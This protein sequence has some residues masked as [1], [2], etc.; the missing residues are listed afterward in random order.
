MASGYTANYS[1]CQWQGE[2]KFLR[3]EFNQD[4]AKI[5]AALKA[6]EERAEEKAQAA[7][8]KADRALS[9]LEAADYNIYNLLLQSEYEGKYT[10]YKKAL[11]YDG[12]LD[13]SGIASKSNSLVITDGKLVLSET[14]QGN[15]SLGS[16]GSQTGY[17]LD[18]TEVTSTGAGMLTGFQCKLYNTY[19]EPYTPT[20]QAILTI[21]GEQVFSAKVT[22][23]SMEANA[24]PVQ[25]F[26]FGKT[27][28]LIAGDKVK[29]RLEN[30]SIRIYY[31][32]DGSHLGGTLLCTG[33]SGST[34]QLTTRAQSLPAFQRA[35]AWVRHK[36]GTVGL[37]L[38]CGDE[39]I[40]LTA[41]AQRETV[42]L[43]SGSTCTEQSYR[44]ERDL[45]AGDWQVVLDAVLGS[46]ESSMQLY[47]YGIAII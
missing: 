18:S 45:S 41:E 8:T 37:S 17:N 33:R 20:L 1:L 23:Q 16:Y 27:F 13:E 38:K 5:D 43:L 40:S 10:G 22:G 9:G 21:N 19:S 47:D 11:L 6:A 28:V 29:L 25:S 34:G 46:G 35:L 12:F 42:D 24:T 4:N 14:G 3:E 32:A 15:L 44:L 30:S 2:D 7:E 39:V 26:S 31:A 36:G